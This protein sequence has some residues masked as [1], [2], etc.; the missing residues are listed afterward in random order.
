MPPDYQNILQFNEG[1]VAAPTAGMHF[2]P[3]SRAALLRHGVGL[4]RL[5]CMVGA[6]AERSKFSELLGTDMHEKPKRKP[7]GGGW[8]L[9]DRL[10]A[11]SRESGKRQEDGRSC[12]S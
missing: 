4:H 9:D 8:S 2:T 5:T 11:D 12:R 1:A 10:T 6:Q 3:H 7:T